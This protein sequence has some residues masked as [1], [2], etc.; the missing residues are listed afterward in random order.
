MKLSLQIIID[1][2]HDYSPRPHP[3]YTDGGFSYLKFASA[4]EIN[5]NTLYIC[6]G[7]G[8]PQKPYCQHCGCISL[9]E[10]REGFIPLITLQSPGNINEVFNHL[11]SLF[12]LWDDYQTALYK[13][14]VNRSYAEVLEAAYA[15]LGNPLVFLDNS[16]KV[17]AMLPDYDFPFDDEWNHMRKYNFASLDGI[18]KLTQSSSF[19]NVIRFV[20]PTIFENELFS[21]RPIISNVFVDS[22]FMGRVLLLDAIKPLESSDIKAVKMLT[23]AL[24]TLI[25]K[26]EEFRHIRGH[27]SIYVMFHDLMRNRPVDEE[28]INHYLGHL[29][30]WLGDEYR[31]L[32]IPLGSNDEQIFGF[33]SSLLD[34]LVPSFSVLFDGTLVCILKYYRKNFGQQKKKIQSFVQNNSLTAGLS[35]EFENII[36]L[37]GYYSQAMT[38]L[39]IAKSGKN[40]HLYSDLALDYLLS[41][42]PKDDP[43]LYCHKAIIELREAEQA[44]TGQLLETLQVFLENERSQVKTAQALGIHRN[45]LLYRMEKINSMLDLDLEDFDL[46]FYLLLSCKLLARDHGSKADQ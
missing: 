16:H 34:K 7:Y 22:A 1:A 40:L 19:K 25:Q 45:T 14:V 12:D 10:C 32:A 6:Y 44:G 36:D 4:G 35:N 11:Q 23:E 8:S 21:N 9:G 20:E 29:P 39:K 28:L 24:T 43:K 13:G 31:V 5:E 33:Y 2:L 26:D 15:F 18:K 30:N 38:S 46:R 27:S 17:Y 41:L 37:Y 3:N 42:L